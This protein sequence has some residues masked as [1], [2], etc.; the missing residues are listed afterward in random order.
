LIDEDPEGRELDALAALDAIGPSLAA[1]RVLEIGCGDGR[2]TR[3]YA[4]D[5]FSIIAIDPDPDAVAELRCELPRVDARAIG[6]ED[7]VMADA[8]LDVV[9]F[10]WS[11]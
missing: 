6:V 1:C 11:L 7:L 4:C 5:A 8:S 9:L 2:L 10:A 3:R